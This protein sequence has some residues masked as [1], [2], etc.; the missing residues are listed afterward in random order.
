MHPT[1]QVPR[2]GDQGKNVKPLA[3]PVS[4]VQNDHGIQGKERREDETGQ[5]AHSPLAQCRKQLVDGSGHG[6]CADETPGH[7]VVRE[8]R[9]EMVSDQEHRVRYGLQWLPHETDRGQVRIAGVED[10]EAVGH[11]GNGVR[12]KRVVL[13]VEQPGHG[14]IDTESEKEDDDSFATQAAARRAFVVGGEIAPLR[15]PWVPLP[16]GESVDPR[17]HFLFSNQGRGRSVLHLPVPAFGHRHHLVAA[18]VRRFPKILATF[19]AIR[20]R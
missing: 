2:G 3:H 20:V 5:K 10:V 13:E 16:V 6:E 19:R 9:P 15:G 7:V 17:F 14:E 8:C 12:R 18:T 1:Q 4:A 11:P